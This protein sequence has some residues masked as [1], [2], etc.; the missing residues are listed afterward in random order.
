[1]ERSQGLPL[2]IKL[3]MTRLPERKE[4]FNHL[5]LPV[6]TELEN[7]VEPESISIIQEPIEDIDWPEVP[8]EYNYQFIRDLASSVKRWRYLFLILP[9]GPEAGLRIQSNSKSCICS[10]SSNKQGVESL[11]QVLQNVNG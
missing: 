9:Q 11:F 3:D 6:L 10:T 2:D 4:Y 5:L 1:M 8:W 7:I